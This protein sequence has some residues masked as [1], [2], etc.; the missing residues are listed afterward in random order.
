MM[1]MYKVDHYILGQS[2]D[3]EPV[4]IEKV[5]SKTVWVVHRNGD[6]SIFRSERCA[7][8]GKAEP[9]HSTALAASQHQEAILLK[10]KRDLEYRLQRIGNGL[11]KVRAFQATLDQDP[12]EAT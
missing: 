7:R 3:P 9:Y 2:R 1:T 4:E 10:D 8:I 11:E 5:T 6:G 12:K